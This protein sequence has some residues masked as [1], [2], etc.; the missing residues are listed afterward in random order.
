MHACMHAVMII[1]EFS[2]VNFLKNPHFNIFLPKR[3]VG[4]RMHFTDQFIVQTIILFS[5]LPSLLSLFSYMLFQVCAHTSLAFE[6]CWKTL[7]D[8]Q[9]VDPAGSTCCRYVGA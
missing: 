5:D 8:A 3:K 7:D 2:E 6:G 1:S 4:T 9:Q